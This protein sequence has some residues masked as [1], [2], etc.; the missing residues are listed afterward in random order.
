MK[1]EVKFTGG[2]WPEGPCE[3]GQ[4]LGMSLEFVLKKYLNRRNSILT[5]LRVAAGLELDEMAK[6]LDI[7]EEELRKLETSDEL[8]SHVLVTRLA[9][10]LKV[11]LKILMACLGLVK[12]TTKDGIGEAALD[13]ALPFAAQYSGP[14]LSKEEKV[15]LEELFRTI[16]KQL[17]KN[18]KAK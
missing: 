18:K 17:E 6:Q 2:Q 3:A 8:V 7:S 13:E 5:L 12:S 11:D 10:V 16:L 4:T 1:E 14:E 9:K 15:N